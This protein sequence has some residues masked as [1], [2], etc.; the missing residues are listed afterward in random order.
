MSQYRNNLPLLSDNQFLTDGGLETTLIFKNGFEL[1]EFAA[2]DVFLQP[3]G[4]ELLREYYQKHIDIAL[5]KGFG[6]ILESP[7]WRASRDWGE[8]LGYS[9][10]DLKDMNC[11][12]ISFLED[13]RKKNET[14][15]TQLVISGCLGPRGDGY[16]LE[17]VMTPYSGHGLSFG[18]DNNL[19][20]NRDGY[21]LCIYH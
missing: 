3:N 14:N 1:P 6:F 2:F 15:S 11:K 18:A 21:C 16:H 20:L 4:C 13:L 10:A 8:K 12:A 17:G 9:I 5:E 19:F 7:T